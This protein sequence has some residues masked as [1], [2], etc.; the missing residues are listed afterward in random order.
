MSIFRPATHLSLDKLLFFSG[1]SALVHIA[2]FNKLW[3][4]KSHDN[5]G[6]VETE[7]LEI[8]ALIRENFDLTTFKIILR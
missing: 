7:S 6:N 5:L 3:A 2:L 8:I 1:Y 4:M